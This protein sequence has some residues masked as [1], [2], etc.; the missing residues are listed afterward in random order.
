MT[1]PVYPEGTDVSLTF[2]LPEVGGS[3]VTPTAIAQTLR[4]ET[5]VEIAAPSSIPV[6]GITDEINVTIPAGLNFALAPRAARVVAL[7]VTTAHGTYH[8][9][10]IYLIEQADQLQ[11]LR[12]TFVTLPE[13]LMIERDLINVGTFAGAPEQAKVNALVNAHRNLC[14]FIY[15]FQA[16]ISQS[17]ITFD[18]YNATRRWSDYTY[19]VDIDKLTQTEW[20]NTPDEFRTALKRGQI[21]EAN[22]LLQGD[23]IG[24]KR[25]A[26]IVSETIGESS[27]FMSQAKPLQLPCSRAALDFLTPY[28]TREVRIAR[29]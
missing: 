4:D 24:D 3:P 9:Q 8:L 12:N 28:I 11:V 14:K 2:K 29:A 21:A 22:A 18:P 25:R 1:T 23:P 15:R 10:Q 5:G 13:A 27:M 17:S 26:G 19:V 7:A 20:D 6:A 16:P